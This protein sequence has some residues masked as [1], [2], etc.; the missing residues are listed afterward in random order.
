M[1]CGPWTVDR[2]P[3]KIQSTADSPRSTAESW[4]DWAMNP[5]LNTCFCNGH[6]LTVVCRPS[7]V[8]QF[9]QQ[10][11]VYCRQPIRLVSSLASKF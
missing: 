4:C 6:E 7:T 1:S 10:P 11:T 2:W 9:S 5:N 3:K 8:D